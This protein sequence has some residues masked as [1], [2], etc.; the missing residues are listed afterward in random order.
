MQ[1]SGTTYVST[2]PQETIF[3]MPMF[4]SVPSGWRSSKPD[5][6]V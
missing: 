6:L 1:Q 5:V 4:V 2:G 3:R